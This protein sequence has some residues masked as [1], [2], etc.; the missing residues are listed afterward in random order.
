MPEPTL[1]DLARLFERHLRAE[2]KADRTIQ[3]YLEAVHGLRAFLATRP[4]GRSLADARREDLEA[5]LADLLGRCKPATAHNRYRAL[6]VF[7][8]WCGLVVLRVPTRG[9]FAPC[10]WQACHAARHQADHASCF[11]WHQPDARSQIAHAADLHLNIRVGRQRPP[12]TAK[13]RSVLPR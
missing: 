10:G 2:N 1:D 7:Y 9:A 11:A 6:R 8:T 3:T 12:A 5:F 4:H 13:R